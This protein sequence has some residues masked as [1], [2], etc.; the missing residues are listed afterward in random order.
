MFEEEAE[1]NE[2]EP[3]LC[4]IRLVGEE[5]DGLYR[6]EF[7]FTENIDECWGEDFDQKPACLVN[8][9]MVDDKYVDEVHTV[10]TNIKFDLVQNNCCFSMSDCYDGIVAVA[11]E[12]IDELDEFPEDGRLFFM[13]GE[14]ISDVERKLAM[15]NIIMPW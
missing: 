7:I 15:K 5:N 3:K 9:L 14:T 8:N 11:W 4:F 6:Y 12:N 13:F 2:E 10:R 1:I